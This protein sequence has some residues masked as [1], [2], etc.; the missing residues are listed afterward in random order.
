M[1]SIIFIL[2]LVCAG[3]SN[4][5]LAVEMYSRGQKE[6]LNKNLAAAEKTFSEVIKSDDD[7]LNAYLMLAKIYYH[8]KEYDKALT[9]VNTVLKKNVNHTGAL[10]WKGRILVISGRDDEE[11]SVRILQSV[12]DL[13]SHHIPA[14][15]LLAL[16]YEKN[17]KYKEALHEYITALNEEESLVSARGNLAVLYRRLGL[18][19]RA[20]Q[21]IERA[22]KISGIIGKDIKTL[23]LIKSEFDK[24]EE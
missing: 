20:L 18:K 23:N 10:Y 8:T 11:E 3:C 5:D 9:N 24:W 15:L 2:L 19:E 14:R 13:D 22:V 17:G 1:K 16:V 4:S 12:L 7:F 21:E 6:F